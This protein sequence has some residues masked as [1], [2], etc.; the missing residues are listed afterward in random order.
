MRCVVGGEAREGRLDTQVSWRVTA[1]DVRSR[2]YNLDFKNPHTTA[3]EHEDPTE[4]LAALNAS[5]AESAI[6]RDQLKAVLEQA[7]KG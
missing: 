6:L 3:R 5:E 7:L 1:D 2:G 4:A